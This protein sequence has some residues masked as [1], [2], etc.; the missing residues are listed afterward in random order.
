VTVQAVR[1]KNYTARKAPTK[2]EPLVQRIIIN[3]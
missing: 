1:G 2:S 3:K